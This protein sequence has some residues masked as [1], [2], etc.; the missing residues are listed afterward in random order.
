MNQ[1]Q[2]NSYRKNVHVTYYKYQAGHLNISELANE[3][4]NLLRYRI[5]K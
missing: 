1:H 2:S 3:N 5:S 4:L